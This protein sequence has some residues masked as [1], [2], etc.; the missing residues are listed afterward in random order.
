MM[1]TMPSYVLETA[2]VE[3]LTQLESQMTSRLTAVVGLWLVYVITCVAFLQMIISMS[4]EVV[5][6][7]ILYVVGC[8]VFLA[9][10]FW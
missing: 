6:C 4:M 9:N 3:D 7:Y 2:T 5:Y 10:M 8:S 1:H